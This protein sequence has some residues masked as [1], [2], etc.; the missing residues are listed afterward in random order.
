MEER[1]RYVRVPDRMQ[2][3]YELIPD[4]KMNEYATEDISQGGIKFLIHNPIPKGS[5]L[6]IRLNL[7]EVPFTFE[8]IVEVAWIKGLPSY[9]GGEY[10]VGVSFINISSEALQHLMKHI[11]RLL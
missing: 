6:K 4:F 8:A 2:I 3:H 7:D 11:R 10:E 5:H 9:Q 1:R